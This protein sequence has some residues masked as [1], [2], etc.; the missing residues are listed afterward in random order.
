MN[1]ISVVL[2]GGGT[3]GHIS[4]LLA[5]ADALVGAAPGTRITTV[6]T[7]SGMETRLV[8]AAGYELETIERV[9]MPRRPSTALLKLPFR[10]AKAVRHAGEIIDRAGADVV[11]G[12]GGYVCTPVYLAARRRGVPVVIHE[13]NARA[14]LANKVGARFAAR[15]AAAF[16]GTSLPKAQVVGMP[17]RREIARLDRASARRDARV[18]LGLDPEK[19]TLV[20]TGGSSGAVTLN[21]ALVGAL[22]AISRAEP[23]VQVLH[24]TGRDKQITGADGEP[25]AAPGYVQVEYVDGMERA[26]AAADLMVC[27]SGAGTVCE[28]AAVGLPSVLVPLP[29][30]NGE[31]RH[32]GQPL[33]D[34]QGAVMVDNADFTA[35]YVRDHVVPLLND[36]AR[37]EAMGRAAAHHGRRDAAEAVAQLVFE[38]AAG[39]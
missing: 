2:A 18:S 25:L 28:L 29:I 19:R 23:A 9:P 20:V 7:A 11:V 26:Y 5:I 38:A 4:P 12:V 15:V 24:V 16:A 14:G 35:D 8:P 1:D 31:Q 39:A 13:A 6:G 21:Q 37:L 3:A 32:N 17:M 30:G 33:V 22:D 36:D 27:R 10:F 34:A